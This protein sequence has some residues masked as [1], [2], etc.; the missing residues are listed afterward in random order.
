MKL[1]LKKIRL[2]SKDESG[3]P[4]VEF[5]VLAPILLSMLFWSFELGLFMYRWVMLD[6]GVDLTVR[7]L[8][9]D[10]IAEGLST[11]EAFQLMKDRICANGLH[12]Q[13]CQ[14]NLHLELNTTTASSGIPS[15]AVAC[16]DKSPDAIQ[17]VQT[18][19][20]GVC[21]SG[22]PVGEAQI[23]YLRAC[24]LAEPV[25]T[26]KYALPFPK[27]SQGFIQLRSS[28]AFLNEPC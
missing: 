28:S 1:R 16:V 23:V 19:Y 24:L 12:L 3:A 22:A 4:S 17:P 26:S 7:E 18:A 27:D 9:L 2:F 5:V 25:M 11:S 8:M 14:E 6:R 10:N 15:T 21:P 20:G 13:D